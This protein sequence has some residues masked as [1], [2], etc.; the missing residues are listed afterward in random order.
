ML[1]GLLPFGSGVLRGRDASGHPEGF[2]SSLSHTGF[3]CCKTDLL[4]HEAGWGLP[5]L[6]LFF[7][8]S[9]G[10]GS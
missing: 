10:F 8:I 4:F 7:E 1:R 9:P 6:S 5:F 2:P 3:T